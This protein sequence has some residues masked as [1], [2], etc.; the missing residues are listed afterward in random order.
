MLRDYIAKRDGFCCGICGKRVRM[1][2]KWP[3]VM[4]PSLDHIVPLSEGGIHDPANC[5]LAHLGCN[6]RK[7]AKPTMRG[8]QL[9]LVG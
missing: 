4:S 6:S 5:V 1:A 9:M 8:Q 7:G 3:D 2:V